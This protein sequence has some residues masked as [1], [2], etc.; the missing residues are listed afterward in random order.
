MC[1]LMHGCGCDGGAASLAVW[2]TLGLHALGL[3]RR[4]HAATSHLLVGQGTVGLRRVVGHVGVVVLVLR[5]VATAPTSIGIAPTH[6]HV[7]DVAVGGLGRLATQVLSLGDG[8][9]GLWLS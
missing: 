1:L 5:R 9:A 2:R 3:E 7:A 6:V 4:R 8:G